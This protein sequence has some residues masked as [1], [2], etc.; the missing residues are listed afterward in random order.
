MKPAML[1]KAAYV[2][3]ETRAMDMTLGRAPARCCIRMHMRVV[4]IL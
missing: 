1:R 3:M 4:S 2:T